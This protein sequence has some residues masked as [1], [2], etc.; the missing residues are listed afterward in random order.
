MD[1]SLEGEI[2]RPRA[3]VYPMSTE[4]RKVPAWDGYDH[5]TNLF[6]GFSG[7]WMAENTTATNQSA[8]LRLLQL[9]SYKLGIYTQASR[10]VVEDGIT[11]EQQLSGALVK[12]IGWYLDYNFLQGNGVNKP[13]GILQDTSRIT[14]SRVSSAK[15][16]YVDTVNMF[17]RMH[18][19]CLEHAVWL[20]NQ[21][22]I[23]QLMQ[24]TISTGTNSGAFVPAVQSAN[25]QFTLHY[26]PI[27]FTEKLPALGTEGD[28]CLV[29]L[30][31][32][33][34]GLRQDLILDR[35]NAP[36]WTEDLLSYRA[37][38]RVDGK[39]TWKTYVTP[40]AGDT[41]SWCVT[42]ETK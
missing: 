36:G 8:L 17:A 42:L 37:I 35:S 20:I 14:A 31:Q 13:L 34:I 28:I 41:L 25:G 21:T 23:P 40:K 4:F 3:T 12:A 18:P 29:D 27:V 24:M 19:S 10:E 5:S 16:S 7:V 32:Y 30:S 1:A 33:A 22:A 26:K 38:L 15:I 2:V 6:G 11:F 9:N 39:P